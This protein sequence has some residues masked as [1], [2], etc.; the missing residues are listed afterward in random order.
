M[1]KYNNAN[2]TDE[3]KN[4]ISFVVKELQ[5]RGVLKYNYSTS[6]NTEKILKCYNKL[7]QSV[8]LHKEQIKELKEN[9]LPKKSNSIKMIPKNNSYKKDE[10]EVIEQT[11]DRLQANIFKTTVFLKHIDRS[12]ESLKDDPYYE[13][14]KLYYI[15]GKT[16]EEIAEFYDKKFNKKDAKTSITTIGSNKNRLINE[17]KVLLFPND[18][19]LEIMGY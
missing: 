12:I 4:V 1:A 10:E 11:I 8:V 17:L 13:I 3:E 5:K 9:G 15:K 2:L 18:F 19:L 7:Q 14:L 16:Q 6:K